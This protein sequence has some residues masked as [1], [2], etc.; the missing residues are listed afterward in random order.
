M[1]KNIVLD[2]GGVIVRYSFEDYLNYFQF[3]KDKQNKLNQLFV[4]TEWIEF[5][6]GNITSDKFREY[7]I[8]TFPEYRE[9]II[10]ILD[11]EN[12]KFMIPPYPDTLNFIQEL[13]TKD[14]K[15]YLL[16]DI[17]EDTIKY[18][19]KEIDN[20]ENLFDGIVYSCRVGYTKRDIEIFEYLL[21]KFNL[22]PEETL[23]LDDSIKNLKQAELKGIHTYQFLNPTIDIVQVKNKIYPLPVK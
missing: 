23:F 11:V 2:N 17:N 16:T 22:N 15:V 7:A 6:K 12:L 20:F 10:K 19:K 3:P 1:I 4:S 14:Y 8:K 13:R 18:L 9:D 21:T 5:A